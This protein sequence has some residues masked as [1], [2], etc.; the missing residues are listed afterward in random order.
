M[1]EQS[2][3][4]P[5]LELD[6]PGKIGP[7]SYLTSVMITIGKIDESIL[8]LK[9]S[10][11]RRPYYLLRQLIARVPDDEIRRELFGL[12]ETELTRLKEEFSNNDEHGRAVLELVSVIAGECVA[13]FDEYI[14]IARK[15]VISK[16]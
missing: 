4:G 11:D 1:N 3:A 9:G 13:Y 5:G 10:T 14:G 12:V 16:V 15:Q 6:I 8:D 2:G 7:E